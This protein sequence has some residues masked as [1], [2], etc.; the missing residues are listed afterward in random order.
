MH[1]QTRAASLTHLQVVI[2]GMWWA[3][4]FGLDSRCGR[5]TK[6]KQEDGYINCLTGSFC[7]AFTDQNIAVCPINTHHLKNYCILFLN[8]HS[9]IIWGIYY[10]NSIHVYSVPWAIHPLYYNFIPLPL[11]TPFSWCLVGFIVLPLYV[12]MYCASIL[13]TLSVLSF[14]APPSHWHFPDSPP[15]TFTH[16]YTS[17][18][19][20]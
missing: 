13:F 19:S 5:V 15:L 8:Y 3:L 18:S 16:H 20:S 12:Y 6:L 11:L 17:S 2:L 1:T 4:R 9:L 7:S 14:P 10:D